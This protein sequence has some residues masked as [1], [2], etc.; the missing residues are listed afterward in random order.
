MT[1]NFVSGVMKNWLL[2]VVV[3]T[4]IAACGSKDNS[5]EKAEA[6]NSAS[7]VVESDTPVSEAS[8][9]SGSAA[10]STELKWYDF[11]EGMEKAK[12]ENKALLIDA[13]TDW[14]G[15]CKV[16]D[17]ET[18][19]DARVIA[20]LNESFVAVKFNPELDKKY[21][22]DGTV[23][24]G[25]GLLLWLAQGNPGGFPTSYFVFNPSK[26]M[27]RA[28]QPGY[29]PPTDFLKLLDMVLAKKG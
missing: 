21:N 15:W 12:K 18:Y 29:L 1:K 9:V 4:M 10:V 17:K 8:M 20:K 28:M 14:C 16:M 26:N 13:Y 25:E 19:K 2:S 22:V 6:A 23:K 5:Q 11:E 27:E 7:S 24:N 3:A